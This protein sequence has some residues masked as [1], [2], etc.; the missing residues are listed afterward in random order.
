MGRHFPKGAHDTSVESWEVF[1]P[2]MRP[3]RPIERVSRQGHTTTRKY[4][5]V[6]RRCNNGWM[7]R[8]EDAARPYLVEFMTGQPRVISDECRLVV[9]RWAILKAMVLE[10]ERPKDAVTTSGDRLAFMNT[11]AIP[12]GVQ[13]WLFRCGQS[14]W[15][16]SLHRH[17]AT[18]LVSP[19]LPLLV[20]LRILRR[21]L[22]G[23]KRR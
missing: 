7:S 5:V 8:V 10:Q 14:P 2:T 6:C 1:T 19:S 18:A 11:L 13:V 17:S 4:K 22:S 16:A 21:C 23:R 15:D 3:A 9:T 20:E 12:R